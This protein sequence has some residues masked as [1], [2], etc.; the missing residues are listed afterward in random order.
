MIYKWTIS[1]VEREIEKDGLNDVIKAVHW[2][3]SATNENEV[4][5]Q[6]YGVVAIG[7]PDAENFKPFEEVTEADVASWLESIFSVEPE[8]E[9]GENQTSKLDHLKNTLIQKIQ[10]KESPKTI[11]SKLHG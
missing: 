3:Y 2:R 5:A 7:E 4:S 8:N 11:T 9:E 6:T 1:A 10:L